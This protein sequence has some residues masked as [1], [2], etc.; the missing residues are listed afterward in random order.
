MYIKSPK[1]SVQHSISERNVIIDK[2]GDILTKK[3]D[4][5]ERWKEHFGEV[6]DSELQNRP[7]RME[8]GTNKY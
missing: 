6:I 7:A 1:R 8:K 3:R 2:D 5:Q 4:I